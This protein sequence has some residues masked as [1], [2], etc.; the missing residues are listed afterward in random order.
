MKYLHRSDLSGLL[1]HLKDDQMFV[2]HLTKLNRSGIRE[3]RSTR[4]QSWANTTKQPTD[5]YD[6][7]YFSTFSNTGW[8][9]HTSRASSNWSEMIYKML[10]DLSLLTYLVSDVFWRKAA[11][12]TKV[13]CSHVGVCVLLRTTWM[14][15]HIYIF[16]MGKKIP[17]R[18]SKTKKEKIVNLNQQLRAREWNG[19]WDITRGLTYS[20][21]FFQNCHV[22]GHIL[23]GAIFE[24][25]SMPLVMLV[26]WLS[27]IMDEVDFDR[28]LEGTT[29][30]ITS[31]NINQESA[32]LKPGRLMMNTIHYRG[33][34]HFFLVSLLLIVD[35]GGLSRRRQRLAAGNLLVLKYNK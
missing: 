32:S 10:K 7:L 22:P 33:S 28:E 12:N 30:L 31:L 5:C 19:P 18:S 21:I 23:F 27:M 14:T 25:C 24:N 8:I 4:Q 20:T 9:D 35:R 29:K 34:I 2:S 11:D 1:K 17:W 13:I 3:R 6:S 16:I 26:L 15:N